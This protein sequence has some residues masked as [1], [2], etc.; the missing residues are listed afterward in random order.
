MKLGLNESLIKKLSPYLG[1][2]S[3]SNNIESLKKEAQGLAIS[4]V[5]ADSINKGIIKN[6]TDKTRKSV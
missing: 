3:D 1:K 5:E 6:F 4:D 2:V